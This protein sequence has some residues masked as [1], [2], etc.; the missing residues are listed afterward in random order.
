MNERI[1]RLK[2]NEKSAQRDANTARALAVVR[3]GHRPP[4]RPPARCIHTNPQTGPITIHDYNTTPQLAS[5]QCNENASFSFCTAHAKNGIAVLGG[6]G[7]CALVSAILAVSGSGEDYVMLTVCV[8][9]SAG[10]GIP[11]DNS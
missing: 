6:A 4:A 1:S 3:F 9:L 7:I 10:A 5:A 11:Q 2:K 8:C